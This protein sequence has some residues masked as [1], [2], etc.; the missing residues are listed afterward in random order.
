MFRCREPRRHVINSSSKML[1]STYH[2]HSIKKVVR[3]FLLA[4]ITSLVLLNPSGG[5]YDEA[6]LQ[7]IMIL[8]LPPLL[9]VEALSFS[10]PHKAYRNTQ[11]KLSQR[12]FGQK[13][14]SRFPRRGDETPLSSPLPTS[15]ALGMVLSTPENIIEQASTIKLLD[16][17]IDESVRTSA[18]KPIMMQFQ[19]TPYW[20]SI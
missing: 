10:A 2:Q 13:R 4:T 17:L 19:P 6:P 9:S 15:T 20:V 16:D 14:G 18:R 11:P 8:P 1:S 3:L 5:Y 7:R 12:L